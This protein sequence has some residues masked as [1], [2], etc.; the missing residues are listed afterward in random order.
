MAIDF[1]AMLLEELDDCDNS[2]TNEEEVSNKIVVDRELNLTM[3]TLT[4]RDVELS[5]PADWVVSKRIAAT[6]LDS[7]WLIDN[8]MSRDGE[9]KLSEAILTNGLK[10]KWISLHNRCLQEWGGS[11]NETTGDI[12]ITNLPDWLQ[13]LANF[14]SDFHLWGDQP[15]NHILINKY[16]TSTGIMA[17][18]DGPKYHPLSVIV[19]LLEPALMIFTPRRGY[20]G[21]SEPLEIL[22]PPRSILIF[23]GSAYETHTHEIPDG[24]AV[25]ITGNCCNASPGICSRSGPRIS[26]TIRR[27]LD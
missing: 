16:T 17:H 2:S 26:L 24:I 19:S 18:T 5:V 15:C 14:F 21:I 9:E 6:K 10:D 13:W 7:I 3:P 4:G 8:V 25:P 1:A 23:T 12:K 20:E 11:T 27:V 22:I